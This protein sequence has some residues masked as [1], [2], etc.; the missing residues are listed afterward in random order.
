M[1]VGRRSLTERFC[2]EEKLNPA[3]PTCVT[4]I[5]FSF[6][7][8]DYCR[9]RTLLAEIT[10]L[11]NM[12]GVG[13]SDVLGRRFLFCFERRLFIGFSFDFIESIRFR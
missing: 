2:N 13:E 1:G 5:V 3:Y 11:F 8:G 12:F 4:L 7:T 10:N 6:P 9:D